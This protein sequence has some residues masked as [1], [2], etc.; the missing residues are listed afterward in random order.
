MKINPLNKEGFLTKEERKIP[1][2]G[3]HNGVSFQT[4]FDL[5]KPIE[6]YYHSDKISINKYSKAVAAF[7]AEWKHFVLPFLNGF[8]GFNCIEFVVKFEIV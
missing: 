8:S 2:E 3:Y 1:Y 5:S 6:V 4:C 7:I